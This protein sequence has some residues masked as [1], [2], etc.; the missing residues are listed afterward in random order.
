VIDLALDELGELTGAPLGEMHA[1]ARA[2]RVSSGLSKSGP[3]W[4]K[5]SATSAAARNSGRPTQTIRSPAVLSAAIVS[6]IRRMSASLQASFRTAQHP[7]DLARP[8]P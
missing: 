6:S 7:A 5:G 8:K 2:R 3:D 4:A 1:V